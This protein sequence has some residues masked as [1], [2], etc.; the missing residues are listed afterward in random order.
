MANSVFHVAFP[1]SDSLSNRVFDIVEKVR[2]SDQPKIFVDTL[3]DVIIDMT[4]EGLVYLFLDSLKH[5]K[6]GS[7]HINAVQFGVNTAK[8]GL[9]LV[10]RKVL[11]SMTDDQLKGIV[12][13]MEM[14]LLEVEEV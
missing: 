1:I 3:T 14:I 13:Y 2:E 6:V 9:E 5:A 4:E 12:E 7:F 8:K 10:G 11:K